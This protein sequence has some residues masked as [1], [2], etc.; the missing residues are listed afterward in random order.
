[1]NTQK[2]YVKKFLRHIGTLL[3]G[4]FVLVVLFSSQVSATSGINETINFQGKIVNTDGTNV[5][6]GNYDMVFELYD[7]SSGGTQLWTETWN[8]GT[9]QVTLTNG[10]FR[11][12]LGTNSTLSGVDFNQDNIWLK[13]TFNGEAMSPRIRF[14][15]VPYAFEAKRVAGLT[16]VNNGGNTLNIA[17]NKTFTV[18]N[19]VTLSGTDATTFTQPTITDTLAGLTASQTLT[20]KTIGSTGLTFSAATV[21]ITT[22]TNE[23]FAIMPNGTGKVGIGTTSPGSKLSIAGGVAIGTTSPTSIFHNA[24]TAPDGG[25]LIEGNVGIGTTNPTAPLNI[26]KDLGVTSGERVL[27]NF[28]R[29][30]GSSMGV[31]MGYRSNGSTE[32]ASFLRSSGTSSLYLGTFDIPLLMSLDNSSGYVGIGTTSPTQYL[33]IGTAGGNLTFSHATGPH[34]ILTG[35]TTDLS[36]MPG[37]N[38]GVGS[39]GA[40]LATLDISGTI[41][42]G[43]TAAATTTHLC[44]GTNNVLAGCSGGGGG[45]GGS[46]A[47][48]YI[49]LWSDSSNLSSSLLYQASSMIGIGYTAPGSKLTVS[50]GLAVGT[51]STSSTYLSKLA[52]DGGALFEGIVGIGTTAPVGKLQIALTAWSNRDTDS[53]HV[54]IGSGTNGYGMRMGYNETSNFGVMNVLK[55]GSAWGKLILQDDPTGG[56]VGI[57]GTGA[58]EKLDIG[59]AGGNLIFSHATGPHQIKTGGTTDLSLMPGGNVGIGYTAPGTKL[60]VSGGLAVGTTSASS[61]YLSTKAPDGGLIVEGNVGIGKTAS[62]VKLGVNGDIAFGN[63]VSGGGNKLYF[64]DARN[65]NYAYVNNWWQYWRGTA[66]EGW[67]WETSSGVVRMQVTASSGNLGIGGSVASQSIDISHA[68]GN[69]TFS[70]ATGPHQIMT[71]GTTDLSLMPGGNVGVG[72]TG[73]TLAKLDVNGTIRVGTTAAA[74]STYLCLGTNNVLAGCSAGAGGV[75]GSGTANYL[76]IWSTSTGLGNS[77]L[78]Q[79]SSLVGIGTTTPGSKLTV[80]GGIAIGSTSASST[81]LSKLAPDGGLIVE[82][83][84]GLGTTGPSY[85][86]DING[87]LRL[88]TTSAPTA[89]A[90]VMYFDGTN[91][92]CSENGSSFTNCIGSG[93]SQWTTSGNN[94]Y[95]TTGNV[96]IGMT[97]PNARLDI[98]STAGA[99][100]RFSY[101]TSS[102]STIT[103]GSNGLTTMTTAGTNA[104]LTFATGANNGNISFTPNGTGS[105]IVTSGVTTGSSTTTSGLVLTANSLQSGNGLYVF[106]SSTSFSSGTLAG[107]EWT[108][109]SSTT[110]TGDLFSIGIGSSGSVG[111]LFNVKDSGTSIFSVSESQITSGLPHAF[112]AAGDV[113]ISYD[114]QFTNQTNSSIKSYGPLTIDTGE[115]FES[116]DLTFRTYNSGD[117][118]MDPGGRVNIG[119]A[120]SPVGK[121]HVEGKYTGKALAVFNE[122]GDQDP[123]TASASGVTMFTVD[124]TYVQVGIGGTGNTAPAT[125]RLAVK[126][127]SGDPAGV[128]GAMYYNDNSNKFRCY[129]NTGWTDCV[130]GTDTDVITFLPWSP[131]NNTSPVTTLTV[132]GIGCM[133]TTNMS[134]VGS[135]G[136]T[137][138]V[139]MDVYNTVRLRYSGSVASGQSGTVTVKL[140]N[141]TDGTDTVSTT[142]NSNTTCTDR[143]S[144]STDVSALTGV[145]VFGLQIGD[146]TTTDDPNLSGVV[147]EFSK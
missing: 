15:A 5:A 66:N 76:P 145:K 138:P 47:T 46:G 92:K 128:E 49:P 56:N 137:F 102:Y 72:T 144:S 40:T 14:T 57:G 77:V 91:F 69:I 58:A 6:N 74:T 71:G 8:S 35:G 61:V 75:S 41:R 39:T 129:Q 80:S 79:A 93:T 130:G 122:T 85:K 45:V 17:A 78:Y 116:N 73:S 109:T 70:S 55:P 11:V 50:G 118:V 34:Q 10:V 63:G 37:G 16:V 44:L 12:A 81:Y 113:G 86:L 90:G 2:S 29:G 107:I 87:A 64:T 89:A 117:I 147:V 54:I 98:G 100:A 132:T 140:R 106:S 127:D 105:V 13:V 38:V 67:R 120:A 108:P 25:L 7:A 142:Y 51:T 141:Y 131:Y 36:L 23:N 62:D 146:A 139:D 4:L 143:S 134:A 123:F 135:K 20:N 21:D 18:N 1:M 112:T 65:E 33:D 103:V 88:Q 104:G 110:A 94:I 119:A 136:A 96:G 114:L 82:G 68:S 115:S 52:P 24:A 124:R 133:A 22:G 60:T 31:V 53:Q 121:M 59:G 26:T 101:D 3:A 28:N 111:N 97:S 126:S 9:S 125:F 95:Y 42:V 19:S 32:T 30:S 48:N 84:V 99:Q 43:T 83:N 27:A